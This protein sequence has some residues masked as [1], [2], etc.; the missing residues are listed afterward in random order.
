MKL[1]HM[2]T[3]DPQRTPTFTGFAN[4][5]YFVFAGASNCNAPCVSVVPSFAW[6]HGDFSPDINVTWLGIVGPGVK[7]LGVTTDVWS[8][9][10]DVRPTMMQLLGLHDDYR[11]DGRDLFEFVDDSHLPVALR[12]HDHTLLALGQAYKQLNACVGQ[13][14]SDTLTASTRAIE[15]TSTNDDQYNAT[16]AALTGLGQARDAV[17]DQIATLFDQATFDGRHVDEVHAKVLLTEANILL[18]AAHV[19]AN[20]H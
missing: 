15:S 14:G 5:D 17:A 6:N 16:M 2:V 11:S 4:P 10:T 3:G 9:Q 19:L 18:A 7:H 8:D 12:G 13:F 1:L 20:A